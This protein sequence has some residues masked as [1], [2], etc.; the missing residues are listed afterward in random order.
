MSITI[1]GIYFTASFYRPQRSARIELLDMYRS[2]STA[3]QDKMHFCG[4]AQY[5]QRYQGKKTDQI[6]THTH[7]Y[8]PFLYLDSIGTLLHQGH[9]VIKAVRKHAF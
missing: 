3:G 2:M 4:I 5:V 7:I 9:T 6:H 1:K 8:I